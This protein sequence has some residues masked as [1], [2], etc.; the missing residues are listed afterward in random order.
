MTGEKTLTIS[1]AN[2][3]GLEKSSGADVDIRNAK[4]QTPLEIAAMNGR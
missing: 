4:G 2:L 3:Q 1:F